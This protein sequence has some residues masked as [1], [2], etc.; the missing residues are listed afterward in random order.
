MRGLQLTGQLQ[1]RWLSAA[2]GLVLCAPCLAD[3]P[4]Y[5]EAASFPMPN[6]RR[7]VWADKG[8]T[9]YVMREGGEILAVDGAKRLLT[10]IA[11]TA[12][13]ICAQARSG[14]AQNKWRDAFPQA[15]VP[16]QAALAGI[17]RAV[18]RPASAKELETLVAGKDIT[19]AL[20]AGWE[21]VVRG[22]PADTTDNF[23]G[24]FTTM[25]ARFNAIP[26][27][28]RAALARFL[29]L[30]E[31]RL[32][33][34]IPKTWEASVEHAKYNNDRHIWFPTDERISP[35]REAVVKLRSEQ[36]VRVR[37]EGDHWFETVDG[38]PLALATTGGYAAVTASGQ[39]AYVALCEDSPSSYKIYA[40]QRGGGRVIWS[41][42][43]W[44]EGCYMYGQLV[45]GRSGPDFQPVVEIEAAGDE[46]AVFG[47]TGP[48]AYIEVFD[49]RTG[50][51]V[52]R[53][54]TAYFPAPK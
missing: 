54:D 11:L 2:L 31:G 36:N 4:A 35:V 10:C 12:L 37:K 32:G 19:V 51:N 49:A 39:T 27:P 33:L 25:E 14:G 24:P 46:V 28:D 13:C 18:I 8:S 45:G 53:F 22:T 15:E 1:M 29:G 26:G 50:R 48:A 38:E 52:C 44:A 9:L 41:S 7:M 47:L 21:R 3:E 40:Q 43:V 34:Q 30:V 17:V 16:S 20:D 5:R 42:E 6:M 23:K